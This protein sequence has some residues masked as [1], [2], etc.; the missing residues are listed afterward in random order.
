MFPLIHRPIICAAGWEKKTCILCLPLLILMLS[1]E[2]DRQNVWN[3]WTPVL[4]PGNSVAMA[5]LLVAKLS[6]AANS[7]AKP[8]FGFPENVA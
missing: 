1:V 2:F 4:E 5:Q 8:D 7:W 6:W 3:H